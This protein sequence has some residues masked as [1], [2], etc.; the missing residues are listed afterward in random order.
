MKEWL[1]LMCF[2]HYLL[3]SI[4]FMIVLI[5]KIS[6]RKEYL[7]LAGCFVEYL[8]YPV[9]C[10][11]MIEGSAPL[12]LILPTSTMMFIAIPGI[13]YSILKGKTQLKDIIG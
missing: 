4:A 5:N 7:Y 13:T 12:W 9:A 1:Y 11:I 2:M 8:T 3:C 10:L 6:N